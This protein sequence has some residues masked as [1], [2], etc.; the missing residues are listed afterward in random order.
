MEKL[1]GYIDALN[2][3]AGLYVKYLI[4][5]LT[6]IVLYEVCCRRLFNSPTSWAF[7][8]TTYIFG[9]YFML[10]LGYVELHHRHIRIDIISQ[11]FPQKV[12]TWLRVL[13]FPAFF[14]PF[15]ASLTWAG[16]ELAADSWAMWEH[17]QSAWRPPI[18]PIKTILPIGAF[19]LLAQGFSSFVKDLR[20]LRG[21]GGHDS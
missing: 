2:R 5:P 3:R 15:V 1:T 13:T 14:I 21:G 17:G 10:G 20:K 6:L 11:Q 8:M 4:L 18:Y 19:L 12:Q 7:D 16:V 9:A